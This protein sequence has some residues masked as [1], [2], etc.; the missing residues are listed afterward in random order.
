MV[1]P[2]NLK[3]KRAVVFG[4]GGSIGAAVARTF[5]AEGADVFLAGRSR[6]SL[7]AVAGAISDAGGRPQVAVV[8]ALDETAVD[9]YLQQVADGSG[10]IDI[11]INATGPRAADYGSGIPAIDLFL[12]AQKVLASQFITARCAA[13]RMISRGSGV[14]I[15]LTSSPARP[16]TTGTAAIGAAFAG[17]ENLTRLMA[18][19]LTGTG[20]RAVCLRTA[21]NPD[22]RTIQDVADAIGQQLGITRAQALGSLAEGTMLKTSPHTQDVTGQVHLTR[23]LFCRSWA[24]TSMVR[25]R[26]VG[27]LAW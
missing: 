9:T 17:I 26:W 12:T 15:F 21:A 10:P 18:L 6:A 20:V 11:E 23:A 7:D 13:R 14:I 3:D 2:S 25:D 4:A 24:D 27:D 8:D 5:A 19:E 16:H 22:S 1:E